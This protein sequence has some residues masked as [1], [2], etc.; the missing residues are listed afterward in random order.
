VSVIGGHSINDEEIKGGFAVT[1]L[2][3]GN[4]SITNSG[5][6]PGDRLVLTK[7]IGTGII[8]FAAQIGLA[9]EEAISLIGRSMATLNRD[10]ALLMVEFGVHACTDVTGFGLL[11]HLSEM[12]RHSGVSAM[13][14]VARVPIFAEALG[15]VREGIIPGAA[16]RNRE[17]FGD[18]IVATGGEEEE[19]LDLLFDAQTSG[20]LLVSLPE[21]N[22]EAYLEAMRKRGHEA[23][24]VI[25]EIV[26]QQ[27][28]LIEAALNEPAN[29]VGTYRVPEKA[30]KR[31][32]TCCESAAV[33]ASCCE[34]EDP[35]EISC[36]TERVEPETEENRM[37]S[38]GKESAQAFMNMMKTV[39]KGGVVDARTKRLVSVALSVAER[40][41]P[42]FITHA[43]NALKE[44]I[45]REEIEEIAWVAI[46]FTG[47]TGRMFYLDMMKKIG[48]G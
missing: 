21:E 8:S 28:H 44:G 36:C 46:S 23:T 25:G 24:S 12:L 40:C 26:A 19:L 29:L 3:R 15:C 5:A 33:E 41:E 43:T 20:G 38:T 1:G 10:A 14:D 42:C 4:G 31:E 11:G 18:G 6:R 2:V 22:A 48:E 37:T 7:P 17:S 35:R 16:E 13:I 32:E 27:D 39:G 30:P 34:H 47:C 9:S 45:T